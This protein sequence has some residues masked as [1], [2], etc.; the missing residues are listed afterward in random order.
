MNHLKRQLQQWFRQQFT[1]WLNKRQPLA[2]EVTLSQKI[3]YILPSRF[4]LWY[5]LLLVLLYLLGTNYQNNLILLM[6]YMLVSVLLLALTLA[7]RNLHNIRVSCAP[8]LSAYAT[9]TLMVPVSLQTAEQKQQIQ[10]YFTY[11]QQPSV[12]ADA[13]MRAMVPLV[14]KKRGYFPLPRLTVHSYYPFG[15]FNCKS[16]LMLVYHFWVFPTPLPSES[17]D[18]LAANSGNKNQVAEDYDTIRSYQAGDSLKLMLWKRL[19]RDPANPVVKHAPS[20]PLPEPDWI[21]I[22]AVTGAA[23][24]LALSK[25][26]YMMLQLEQRSKPYGL[27]IQSK[28]ISPSCGEQ[29]LQRCL[30]E[31]A[32]C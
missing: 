7:W 16:M 12:L 22:P 18:A 11:E 25:A 13:N 29:H 10:C 24:E 21:T 32:L 20:V 4:G 30:R 6:S 23:L 26:C 2:R 19:A 14:V 9:E 27:R 28:S 15:L 1:S 31:L 8:V 5:I 17:A 3:I